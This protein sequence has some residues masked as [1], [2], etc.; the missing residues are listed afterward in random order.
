MRFNPA[1]MIFDEL[2][3][4]QEN[5]ASERERERE[6]VTIL[7]CLK[8]SFKFQNDCPLSLRQSAIRQKNCLFCQ[9]LGNVFDFRKAVRHICFLNRWSHMHV[10]VPLDVLCGVR[11]TKMTMHSLTHASRLVVIPAPLRNLKGHNVTYVY[12]TGRE[13]RSGRGREIETSSR[14]YSQ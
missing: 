3:H 12:V 11:S 5:R 6:S 10:V 2:A 4:F 1:V 8:C 14:H 7:F 13:R 9:V